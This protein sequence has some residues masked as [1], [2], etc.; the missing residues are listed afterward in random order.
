MLINQIVEFQSRHI[1]TIFATSRNPENTVLLQLRATSNLSVIAIR[2]QKRIPYANAIATDT[3]IQSTT[4]KASLQLLSCAA[5][6]TPVFYRYVSLPLDTG[7]M[8]LVSS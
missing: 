3:K 4:N 6:N 7:L 1:L 5:R 8:S 2:I